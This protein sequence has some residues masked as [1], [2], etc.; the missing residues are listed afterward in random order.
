MSKKNP[1][2]SSLD[3]LRRNYQLGSIE[4]HVGGLDPFEIFKIW[5]DEAIEGGL[6]EP[7]AMSLAT[8]SKTGK[9]SLRYVLLKGFDENGLYFFT[10]YN[11]PKAIDI[12]NNK[13]VAV[14]FFWD[15]LER[16]VRVEGQASKTSEQTSN[17]YFRSRP[18]I[19]QLS[20]LSSI[21][22]SVVD[23]RKELELAYR[24]VEA[25][26]EGKAVERPSH[27]GGYLIV[28]STFEFWQ[29]R[30]GRLHDRIKF[31]KDDDQWTVA[32][33]SP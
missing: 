12:S 31:E 21:Q 27:W 33:L 32:R 29:G 10:N 17:K 25:R 24:A 16:Q 9:P 20:A 1:E 18:R 26:Y 11:S 3:S 4:D 13:N 30:P 14:S 28:P 2:K 15:S 23:N 19:S 7:N 22:S 8:V 5:M 6:I